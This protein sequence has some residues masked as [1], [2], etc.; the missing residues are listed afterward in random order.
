V[1]SDESVNNAG[2]GAAGATEESS[3]AQAQ[4]VVDVNFFGLVR[5]TK[6]VLPHMRAQGLM[7]DYLAATDA[8]GELPL[9]DSGT[10]ARALETGSLPGRRPTQGGEPA[11]TAPRPVTV[12]TSLSPPVP[13]PVRGGSTPNGSAR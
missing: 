5:M 11:K 7:V 1:T 13:A 10:Y 2:T 6:A 9:Y 3:V 4:R 12:P 8:T